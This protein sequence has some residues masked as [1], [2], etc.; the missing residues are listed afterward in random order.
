M[1]HKTKQIIISI[2]AIVVLVA[3]AFVLFNGSSRISDD[4]SD[5]PK[6]SEEQIQE[7]LIKA[8]QSEPTNPLSEEQ[9]Q[10]LLIQ[11]AQ[12]GPETPLSEEQRQKLLE[13]IAIDNQNSN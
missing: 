9:T 5:T 10:E 1:S 12:S 6:L 13:Q 7:I 4:S 2:L 3:L 11:M 8:A